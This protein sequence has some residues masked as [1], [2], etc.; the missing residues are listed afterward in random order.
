MLFLLTFMGMSLNRFSK[1]T[2]MTGTKI[3]KTS[4]L[5]LKIKRNSYDYNKYPLDEWDRFIDILCENREYQKEA[6]K[7]CITYLIT[8]KYKTIEDVVEE[9]FYKND[10]L[11]E[12]FN[13]LDG[14]KQKIQLPNRKSACVD[15]ATGTGKSYVIYG[16]AQIALGL[17]LVDKVLVLGPS[18]TTI[19]RGLTEKFN[20]LS[21]KPE[22]RNAI[23][24]S[25]HC[26]SVEII[27]ANSTITTHCI[28][29]ENINAVYSN[30][31][32]SIQDSLSFNGGRCLVLNDEIHHAYN[33][34]TGNNTES[35]SIKKWKEFLLD[36]SY[37]FNYILGFTGTAYI[38]NDYFNDVI[39]RYSLKDAIADGFV[40]K[41]NYIDKNTDDNENEKFQ[42]I[43]SNHNKN[44]EIY[45]NIKP[46]TILITKDIREA[47]QLRTRLVEF[48]EQQGQ[49]KSE[50]N[51]LIVTSDPEHKNNVSRLPFVD[52]KEDPTEWIISVAMLTEGWDVK[53]VFQIVPME[54]K[55]FNSKLLIAQVLG[56]GLRI[57]M[58]YPRAEVTV[59]NHSRWS[60]NIKNLV[61]EVLEQET[62]IKNN[63]ITEGN[64]NNFH[65]NLYNI[66]YKKD[67][68][69]IVIE[70]DIQTFNYKSYFNF[71]SEVFSK[72]TEIEYIK[73]GN[74]E[75]PFRQ[76]Y[77]INKEKYL[78]SDIL[79]KI[80]ESFRI[81]RHERILLNIDGEEYTEENLP[82]R[83][84]I[85]GMIKKSMQKVGLSG[86]YLGKANRDKVISAFNTLLRKKT[87]SV[88][89]SKSPDDLVEISTTKKQSE[90]I[91]LSSLINDTTI[92]YSD[93]YEFE[94]VDS[95]SLDLLKKLSE[96][97]QYRGSL[98]E[99]GLHNLKTPVDLVFTHGTPEEKFVREL[100]KDSN[101]K[102]ISSWIKSTNQNFYTIE[103]SIRK[104]SHSNTH[105]FNPDFFIKI[106]K[107]NI[108]YISVIEIKAD[109]DDSDENVQ[110]YKYAKE[111]LRTLNAELQTKGI[112]QHYLFDFLSPT[113]YA[114]YFEYLRNGSLIQGHFVSKLDNLLN[115]RLDN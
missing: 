67:K 18:S 49:L 53:N 103:Y 41:I 65:F 69:E 104:G 42:K 77:N 17:G 92:F 12:K 83:E 35:R 26:K 15:L 66:S 71:E 70:K 58:E 22:L 74:Q 10:S 88:S 106:D 32:S 84:V 27:D 89:I 52:D 76:K 38:N 75:V 21:S 2:N 98:I 40:K 60:S 24:E 85:E 50:E 30:T 87:K 16:I 110:K 19:E 46:L 8:D 93:D 23:P 28:C 43:L 4:D 59:F 11:K 73:V 97:R 111:H 55:A 31:N 115:D 82:S 109:N 90:S 6:I 86:E 101:A 57:P 81:R 72:E 96:E 14:Y 3:F 34:V 1:Q 13:S 47:K 114:E 61:Q 105:M 108:E 51:V 80:E 39:Y 107:D 5:V 45:C 94:I 20:S 64:R 99:S 29:I 56:R 79:D 91:S 95:T 7:T 37:N 112:N 102:N 25:S 36:N 113:N 100:I 33:K 48:L 63:V 54:D 78:I 62:V 44:K 68:Q 9:N